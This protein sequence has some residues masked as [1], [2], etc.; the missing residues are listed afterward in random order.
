MSFETPLTSV[1]AMVSVNVES[2]ERHTVCAN[3]ALIAASMV[4]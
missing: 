1:R 3:S 2:P 4:L